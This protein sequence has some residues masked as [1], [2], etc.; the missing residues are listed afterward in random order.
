MAQPRG[1][2]FGCEALVVVGIIAHV[3]P[4]RLLS[5]E[6]PYFRGTVGYRY[7][8]VQ[9]EAPERRDATGFSRPVSF[10]EWSCGYGASG[11]I[12][13]GK[14][15]F[16]RKWGSKTAVAVRWRKIKFDPRVAQPRGLEFGCAGGGCR[17]C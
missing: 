7:Q 1:L 6:N 2:G 8:K 5:R 16:P 10:V 17:H 4:Y 9:V 12:I 15:L 3:R 13:P 14:S 11:T